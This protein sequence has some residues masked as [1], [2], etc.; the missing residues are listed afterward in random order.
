M[1]PTAY[2]ELYQAL[3]ITAD[4][5]Y[6]GD[7]YD[8]S[9]TIDESS[10]IFLSDQVASISSSL[11]SKIPPDGGD[12]EVTLSVR[13]VSK[14]AS[15]QLFDG[16]VAVQWHAG[17]EDGFFNMYAEFEVAK[18]AANMSYFDNQYAVTELNGISRRKP[19]NLNNQL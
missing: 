2:P 15:E 1:S 13:D 14:N 18:I 8:W 6:G 17:S 16:S 12:G 4:G 10:V 5:T 9:F 19:I 11:S 3:S 7:L